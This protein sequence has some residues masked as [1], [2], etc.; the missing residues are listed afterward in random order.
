MSQHSASS[1]GLAAFRESKSSKGKACHERVS[2]N[3]E[4][5]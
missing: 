4:I 1:E 3:F 2:S 5:Y